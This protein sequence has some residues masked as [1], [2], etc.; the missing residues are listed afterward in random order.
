M[1]GRREVDKLSSSYV[2]SQPLPTFEEPEVGVRKLLIVDDD[3]LILRALERLL[4]PLPQIELLICSNPKDALKLIDQQDIAV[5]ISDHIMPQMNGLD[6][7][8]YAGL[9]SPQTISI[10]LTGERDMELAVKAINNGDVFRF[11]TKPWKNEHLLEMLRLALDQHQ[12]NRSRLFYQRFIQTQNQRLKGINEELESRVIERTRELEESRAQIRNLYKELDGSF[13]ATLQLMLSLM[14]LGDPVIVDH[15]ERT[16]TRVKQFASY[17]GLD[18][19]LKTHLSRAALLHWL[20]LINAPKELLFK[21][22]DQFNPEEKAAWEF[23][24]LLG[25]QI[26]QH[27]PSLNT[28]GQIILHYMRPF[29]KDNDAISDFFGAAADSLSEEILRCCFILHICS[30]F[31]WERTWQSKR[32]SINIRRLYDTSAQRLRMY[33]SELYHPI[34]VEKFCAYLASAV[35]DQRE[36][37]ILYSL[38]ELKEGMILSRPIETPSGLPMVAAETTITRELIERLI[39]FE[40]TYDE[41]FEQ[42]FVWA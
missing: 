32:Q 27:I 29:R 12:L 19:Q 14:E 6:L 25:Q 41:W 5:I 40:D 11:I 4:R 21:P 26:L 15:C 24:P 33:S 10:M 20:G 35:E 9:T 31:E 13:D 34:L 23:H 8:R 39:F 36:E 30:A 2:L 22:R 3:N 28:P 16:A 1:S 38:M 7:L 17:L 42:I 18:E 37:I